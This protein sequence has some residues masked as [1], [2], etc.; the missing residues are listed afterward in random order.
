MSYNILAQEYGKKGM[1]R[2]TRRNRVP[3]LMLCGMICLQVRM[4]V[5]R[6]SQYKS[7]NDYCCT[8]GT[9][10][11]NIRITEEEMILQG[12]NLTHRAQ[13]EDGGFLGLMS[14]W[15]SLHWLDILR[16]NINHDYYY[17]RLPEN[18]R[19][20]G[21]WTKDHSSKFFQRHFLPVTCTSI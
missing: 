17:P 1:I 14:V 20:R 11:Q 9:V 2:N 5:E 12:E 10:R 19:G 4:T 6:T 8:S 15:H 16:R 7:I 21:L 18:E 3:N 13:L